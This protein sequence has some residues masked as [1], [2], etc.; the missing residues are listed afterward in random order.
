MT[1]S[2]TAQS[3]DNISIN[4]LFETMQLAHQ[5]ADEC[6]Q[7]ANEYQQAANVWRAQAKHAALQM[8]LTLIKKWRGG[9]A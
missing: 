8:R 4:H 6:Q 3:T 5:T 9:N 2:I 7:W 1:T